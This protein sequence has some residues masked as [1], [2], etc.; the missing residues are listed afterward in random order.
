MFG[1]SAMLLI[2]SPK[3]LLDKCIRLYQTEHDHELK[4]KGFQIAKIQ[5]DK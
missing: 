3:S 2:L 5:T 1:I 4:K